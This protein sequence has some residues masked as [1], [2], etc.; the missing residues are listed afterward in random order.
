MRKDTPV[1]TQLPEWKKEVAEKVKAY[2]ER[3]KRLTTPPY[4]I[5]ETNQT[6]P[7]Y[8][9]PVQSVAPIRD[10]H[11]VIEEHPAPVIR[12]DPAKEPHFATP[13]E[14]VASSAF[15]IWPE[16][17]QG[18][19]PAP[20]K[21]ESEQ[22]DASG[23]YLFRR[24]LAG[25]VDHAILILFTAMI[26]YGVSFMI[27]ESIQQLILTRWKVSLPLFL[28]MHFIYYLYFYRVSRQTPGMLFVSL[29]LR[30]PVVSVIP[31]GKIIVRW[32]AFVLL[33]IFNFLPVVLGKKS[34][35]LDRIS[36]TEMRSFK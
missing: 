13:A 34:L 5:K 1:G 18:L 17:I 33:N 12:E 35:L 24:L 9:T 14:A 2:G 19:A 26:L 16:D 28:L 31:V 25:C 27:G 3:K 8:N 30:D 36:G 11:P 23:S 10:L 21:E 4:P 7:A 22:S 15:E 20:T 32:F 29:E 6:Q